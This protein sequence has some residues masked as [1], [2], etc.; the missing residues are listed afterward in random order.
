MNIEISQF[1]LW[2]YPFIIFSLYHELY[3]ANNL[4]QPYSSWFWVVM[5]LWRFQLLA[6]MAHCIYELCSHQQNSFQIKCG[7]SKHDGCI[8]NTEFLFNLHCFGCWV[9]NRGERIAMFHRLDKK[10]SLDD[11]V[12][13]LFFTFSERMPLKYLSHFLFE[14]LS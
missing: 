6:L 10:W 2:W 5:I 14:V 7:Y 11:K 1:P 4:I 13:F 12:K 3:N 8:S 9:I